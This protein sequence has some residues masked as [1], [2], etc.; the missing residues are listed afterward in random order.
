MLQGPCKG[1]NASLLTLAVS[2][3]EVKF[4]QPCPLNE[5]GSCGASCLPLGSLGFSLWGKGM[6]LGMHPFPEQKGLGVL[7]RGIGEKCKSCHDTLGWSCAVLTISSLA[8]LRQLKV[9]YFVRSLDLS[10]RW[11]ERNAHPFVEQDWLEIIWYGRVHHMEVP[12]PLD[13]VLKSLQGTAPR[14]LTYLRAAYRPFGETIE[15]LTEALG[16]L[17]RNE[18]DESVTKPDPFLEIHW[19]VNQIVGSGEPVF[20]NEL[21]EL[22]AIEAVWD[23]AH[24]D[25]CACDATL[26]E[27]CLI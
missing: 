6:H 9:I 7:W 14:H 22:L 3:V 21:Q 4:S 25:R 26:F 17:I 20:V 18:V 11:R 1:K 16:I 12:I 8:R 24:H 27:V 2:E 23:V 19:K 13:V 5:K 15:V 10:C